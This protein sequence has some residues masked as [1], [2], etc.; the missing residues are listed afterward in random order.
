MWAFHEQS[1]VT[2]MGALAIVG[3]P[4]FAALH[5]RIQLLFGKHP[6]C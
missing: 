4:N 5:C 1:R 6:S 3:F 2:Q